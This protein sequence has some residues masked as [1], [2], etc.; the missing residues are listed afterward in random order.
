MNQ[1]LCFRGHVGFRGS[2]FHWISDWLVVGILIMVC[3]PLKMNWVIS[4]KSATKIIGKQH[5][6]AFFTPHFT[7]CYILSSIEKGFALSLFEKKPKAPHKNSQS[8][9]KH[10]AFLTH[11]GVSITSEH[12][13]TY[14]FDPKRHWEVIFTNIVPWWSPEFGIVGK[15]GIGGK[16]SFAW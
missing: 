16:F 1:P 14:P 12:F 13:W 6:V 7:H 10:R 3:Y 15:G 5:K 4:T 8:R 11:F 9:N 2:T